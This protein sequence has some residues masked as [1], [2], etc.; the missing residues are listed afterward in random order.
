MPLHRRAREV[1]GEY[2]SRQTMTDF[3]SSLDLCGP[4]KLRKPFDGKVSVRSSSLGEDKFLSTRV[5]K[6][7]VRIEWSV[8]RCIGDSMPLAD[9]N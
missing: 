1:L 6:N 5:A 3:V 4:T 9:S 2:G 7:V 8:W